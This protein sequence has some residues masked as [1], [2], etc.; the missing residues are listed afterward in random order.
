MKSASTFQIVLIAVF[1]FF[2]IF[3]L[4]VFSGAF[5]QPKD[6]KE[7]LTGEVVIWGTLP[8]RDMVE[9]ISKEFI[10]DKNLK[11]TYIEHERGSFDRELIEALAVNEGPDIIL[12]PQNLVLRY[13]D[14]V[15]VLSHE[16]I[17]A[18]DFKNTFIEG[19][20]IYLMN[21]GVLALPFVVDPLVMYWN[22]DLFTSA[23]IVNP[24]KYWDEFFG[25]ASKITKKSH[26]VDILK[27]AVA[28]GEYSNIPHAKEVLTAMFIQAGDQIIIITQYEN[29]FVLE[30]VLGRNIKNLSINPAESALQFYTEFSNPRKVTYSWN[31]SLSNADNMFAVGD[32]GVYFGF[33][34]EVQGLRKRNPH[35]NFDTALFPQVRDS[36][37]KATYGTVQGLSILRN[38]HNIAL[39]FEVIKRIASSKLIVELTDG[40][41]VAPA[42]REF[43]VNHQE[44]AN[45]TIFYK[46][47]L[48]SKSWIDPNPVKTEVIFQAMIEDVTSGRRQIS[49]AISFAQKQLDRLINR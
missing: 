11:V 22:R 31:R 18:R 2:A 27:S 39:S 41:N 4:L 44:D 12:L 47:A 19:G 20:E 25:I 8:S 45:R 14:K 30:S 36:N 17:P 15:F 13:L 37:T 28:L 34:S 16:L 43:L 6:K 40:L 42:Q 7:T 33:A 23:G 32:L 1:I 9:L 46:S 35:L 26:G 5:G 48:I 49:D 3:G 38:S 29:N 24:P 21:K 10:N